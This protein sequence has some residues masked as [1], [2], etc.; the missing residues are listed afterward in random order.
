MIWRICQLA[1]VL[2]GGAVAG[3]ISVKA[4]FDYDTTGHF[5]IA[6]CAAW[7]ALA[8]LACAYEIGEWIVSNV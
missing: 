7:I 5:I 2:A 6:F 8:C 1:G 3:I 4:V